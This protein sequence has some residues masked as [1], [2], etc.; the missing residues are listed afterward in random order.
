MPLSETK[1]LILDS[2]FEE[3]E[4]LKPYIEEL[5]KW[6]GFNEENFNRI[7][8]TLSE[9]VNNAIMHGNEEDP[10]KQVVIE[11][12]LSN[13]KKMLEIS[14]EDEGEGF[15]PDEIPDPL[16]D[17]NLMNQGGRGVYLIK[18]YADDMQFSKSGS[19]V[20]ISFHLGQ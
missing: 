13:D 4:R 12:T 15:D 1:K 7:M 19:K 9:A 17:E 11:T 6:A 8:L 18:Q 10:G 16:K 14:V 5:R 2:K 20:T 3:M